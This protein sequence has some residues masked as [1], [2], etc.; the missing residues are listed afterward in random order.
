MF[1]LQFA[2]ITRTVI[3]SSGLRPDGVGIVCGRFLAL[4]P[5]DR[6]PPE[7]ADPSGY[8]CTIDYSPESGWA[9][10]T[11]LF[12]EGL[13]EAQGEPCFFAS[14]CPPA[15]RV[16]VGGDAPP[17]TPSGFSHLA[18]REEAAGRAGNA[19]RARQAAAVVAQ[20]RPVTQWRTPRMV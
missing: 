20:A 16:Y 9:V 5:A 1:V 3:E 12:V 19:A 15:V 6:F 7:W 13:Y 18:R 11:Q 17:L 10:I 2:G 4:N 14:R 8:A